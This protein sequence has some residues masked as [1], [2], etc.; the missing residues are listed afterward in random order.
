MVEREHPSISIAR[1]CELLG[2]NRSTFY[3]RSKG[4][5]LD[6]LGIMAFIDEQYTETPF[7]GSRKMTRAIRRE[8]GIRINRKR[9]QRLMEKMSI[10]AIYSKPRTT[11]PHPEHRKYP[12]LLRGVEINRVNQ[13]WSTDITY[14]RLQR[15]FAYLVAIMDWHSRYVLSW[16]LS[17]TMDSS[18]CV[19]ALEE[20]LLS[21]RPEIFNSDQGSQFTSS[22]FIDVLASRGISISMDGRGRALDNIF[23][24]RLWRSVKYENVYLKGYATMEEARAGLAA[25]F[26]LY[27]ERRLH[28]SLGYQTPHEVHY[29]L[30]A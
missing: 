4:G 29:D 18:F 16:R 2:L 21:G 10:R 19:E 1:Q 11:I 5:S 8:L 24:E 27:N 7:Y 22:E 17:N 26:K 6:N 20:A 12:Y 23:I 13:A 25:Y 30:A 9:V 15:G 3:Y 14:I 28:E